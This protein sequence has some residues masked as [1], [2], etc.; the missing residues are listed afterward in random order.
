MP[1][2]RHMHWLRVRPSPDERDMHDAMLRYAR[3][4]WREGV[5]NQAGARLAIAVL[6]RRAASSAVSLERSIERRLALLRGEGPLPTAQLALPFD[7]SAA[8]DEEPLAALACPALN[9]SEQEQRCLEDVL[10]FARLASRHES[11]VRAVHRL[12]S[13]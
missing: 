1:V 12:L 7:M 9:D 4:A 11:K 8:D 6:L 10:S 5:A 13:R 3:R 2:Q